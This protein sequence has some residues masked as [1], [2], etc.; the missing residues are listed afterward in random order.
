MTTQKQHLIPT[1]IRL[2]PATLTLLNEA[3]SLQQITRADLIRVSIHEKLDCWL[4]R[5][6]SRVI[7]QLQNI[8]R[9]GRHGAEH[10]S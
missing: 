9:A 8:N 2:S 6:R 10:Q 1:T 4:K 5:D 7:A 3:S